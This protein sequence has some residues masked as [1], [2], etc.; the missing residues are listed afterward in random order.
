MSLYNLMFGT[1]PAADF[2]LAI[3]GVVRNEV[4]RFRDCYLQGNTIVIHTRTGGG[5][6]EE[7]Q[8]ENAWL[9]RVP[10]FL[11]DSDSQIDFTYAD[12]AYE[13]PAKF[14][15]ECELLRDH[16]AERNPAKAWQELF[17][18]LNDPKHKDDPEVLAALAAVKPVID[19]I[20]EF[21]P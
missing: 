5:N 11:H 19:K 9:T 10:G 8:A 16:G 1:N 13:I 4:P 18:K 14:K 21:I 2:L 15:A 20:K 7:Y 12:F 17:A 6:R 3:L